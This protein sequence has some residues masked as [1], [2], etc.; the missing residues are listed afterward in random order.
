MRGEN[1]AGDSARTLILIGL[2]FNFVSG[3][4]LLVI[5]LYVAL[6]VALLL[7]LGAVLVA[8]ALIAF[9]WTALVWAFSYERTRKGDYDGARLPTLIFGILTL[10]S[11]GIIPGVLYLIAYTRLVDAAG[12]PVVLDEDGA[13][14]YPTRR[15]GASGGRRTCAHCGFVAPPPHQ[16]C[17]GCG[18]RND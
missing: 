4:I 16:P 12:G 13:G 1:T 7:V 5:G 10:I 14:T 8:L 3:L 6:A 17:P 2:A 11:G 9:L 18:Y 15:T